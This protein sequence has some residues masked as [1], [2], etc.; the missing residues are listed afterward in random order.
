MKKV[1]L[2]CCFLGMAGIKAQTIVFRDAEITIDGNPKE[3]VW[4]QL[5]EYTGFYNHLPTDE[6]LAENQTSVKLFH[7]GE[8]LYISAIYKDSTSKVQISS[9]KRD[10]LTNT[11]SS[12]D[13]FV[14]ILDTQYQQQSAC[15]FAV[16]AGGAQVDG[17][18]ERV[19]DGDS[20]GINTSWN[21]VWKTNT[22]TAGDLKRYEIEIPLKALNYNK[23]NPVFGVQ[24]YVRDIKNNSWTIFKNVKRNYRLFD[25]RFTEAFDVENLPDISASRFAVT[26]S[27]TVNHQNDVINDT[28]T[29]TIKPSLD[30]QYNLNSSLKLDAT[31]NPDFSQIDVDQQVTNLTRFAV[32][33]PERRNFF[34]ENSDLFSNLGADGVNPFYSR[35]IGA[36]TDIQFGLKLSGNISPKTRLGVLNVQTEKEGSAASQNYGVLVTEHQLSKNFTTTGFLINRQQ[37][38]KFN[39]INEYNRVTGVNL[40]YK[41][42]NNRW[43]GLANYGRSFN[44]GVSGDNSFYNAGIWYNKRGFLWNA[45]VKNIGRNYMADV[46]FIPRLNHYD[47]LNDT[48][49]R[50]GYTQSSTGLQLTKYPENSKAVNSYRY[51]NFSNDTYWDDHG[52]VTESATFY[53]AAVFFKD[54]SAVYFNAYHNY[55]NLKYAFD[56]LG[57]GHVLM[58]DTYR[59]VR[60]RIG[61][62]SVSNK[63]LVYQ[64]YIHH[65]EYYSGKNSAAFAGLTYRLLPLANLGISYEVNALDLNEL[66]NKT[67]HLAQFTGEVFFSNRLNWTTYVQ[68]N[69]QENNFNIN[70]RL[71]WEY[72]PLSYIYL[73]VTDNYSDTISRTDWGVAFKMNYRFDL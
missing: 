59:F 10:D 45:S 61:Y 46:G 23:N 7:N 47:A 38:D 30:V 14:L 18:I 35:R 24:F 71:Q 32:F 50:E 39:F 40:N 20:Y 62:N 58:P 9:L 64:G 57:N 68:Y 67:F 13:T 65:G 55:V 41:S 60:A 1:V 27:V 34:L 21:V 28:E 53:N 2:L 49:V 6:G 51:V 3:P 43:T 73:V 22:S 11:V 25:L 69:T 66:G 44:H 4:Q 52:E 26:P 31:I 12:S 8:Y 56:P 5:P 36:G 42:D 15:Y 37:T 54:L 17:L 33:F 70:S 16:N 72:K 29:T 48:V 63:K 19:G